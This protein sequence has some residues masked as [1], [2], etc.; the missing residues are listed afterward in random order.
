MDYSCIDVLYAENRRERKIIERSYT[1]QGYILVSAGSRGGSENDLIAR[2]YNRVIMHLDETY[3]YDDTMRL[4]VRENEE[5][6]LHLLYEG[7]S[8]TRERLCLVVCKNRNLFLKIL[9]IR[10]GRRRGTRG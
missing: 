7:M 2:E 6:A 1:E 10:I 8:R 5:D 3:Y 9:S 4:R